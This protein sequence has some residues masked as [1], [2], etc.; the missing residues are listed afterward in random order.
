M[1]AI[2]AIVA[3]AMGSRALL[4]RAERAELRFAELE[5]IAPALTNAAMESTA[6][7][8][9][10]ILDRVGVLVP[11]Q[12]LLCF[13]VDGERLMLGAKRGPPYV[14]FLREG[15]SHDGDSI[16]DWVKREAR[17]AITGPAPCGALGKVDAIDLGASP[18]GAKLEVGPI[19]GSRNSL[20]A[21][22]V[23]MLRP[24]AEGRRAEVVGVIYADRPK[25]S[26]FTTDDMLTLS[27]IA[28]LAGDALQRARFTD[29]V[30]RTSA[31]DGLTG[32]LTPVSF[33]KRLRDEV[34]ARRN[35]T[36][37][38]SVAL[39]FIDT[40]RF[41]EWNDRFGHAAGD[42]L[43]KQLA[44]T[45]KDLA[46]RTEGF[47]GRNG[48]DE[49]CIAVLDG[50]KEDAVKLAR[51]L[52]RRV[53]AA[54]FSSRDGSPHVTISIGLA[55]YP[56]DVDPDDRQPADRLLETA[57]TQMYEAKRAG[58]NTFSYAHAKPF[59]SRN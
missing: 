41:K 36:A 35:R 14:E 23:P 55:Q 15:E 34:E 6:A 27:T 50:R 22:A 11:A 58:R 52:C 59:A 57:D 10:R 32:L 19:A 54:D 25:K 9:A 45:F 37:P 42:L 4:R 31:T 21:T 26:P 12:T 30:R 17:A 46:D 18:G 39:F 16:V 13:Y 2:A 56:E 5:N 33:R 47:A 24:Q 44:A 53:A 49:F 20:W 7:T 8:C 1:V 43:L 29:Q 51:D 28:Q 40:D 38:A 3:L 48:G